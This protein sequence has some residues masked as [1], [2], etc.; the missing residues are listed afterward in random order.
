[1]TVT[2]KQQQER[3]SRLAIRLMAWVAQVLGRPVARAL[4]YPICLYYLCGSQQAN[5]AL[6]RYY[7]HL[8]GHAPSWRALF[9]HYHSFAS[10]LSIGCIVCGAGLICS[11]SAFMGLKCSIEPW[12]GDAAAFCSDRISAVSKSCERSDCRVNGLLSK[13]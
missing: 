11:I 13:C 12:R 8:Q 2:W 7:E 6:R 9:R 10:T 3:G 5:R 1:M 4:L